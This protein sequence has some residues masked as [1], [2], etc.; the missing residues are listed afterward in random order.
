MILGIR[1]ESGALGLSN[2]SLRSTLHQ[3]PSFI[4]AERQVFRM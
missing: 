4:V 2:R 1:L 3:L